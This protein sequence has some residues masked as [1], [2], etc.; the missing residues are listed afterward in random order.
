MT[1]WREYLLPVASI[2]A[3]TGAAWYAR[4][5]RLQAQQKQEE[6]AA[7]V[8][9]AQRANRSP[10]A[11]P[12]PGAVSA[13][14]RWDGSSETALGPE[15]RHPSAAPGYASATA[16]HPSPEEQLAYLGE[17]FERESVDNE[18]AR[19]A[20]ISI[21]DRLEGALPE[22]SSVRSVECR[23]IICK[24]VVS[25]PDRDKYKAYEDRAIRSEASVWTGPL[26]NQVEQANGGQVVSTT[27]LVRDG[28]PV[29]SPFE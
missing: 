7:L 25:H 1:A 4:E 19:D 6:M 23:S 17:E 16:P 26:Y 18:W 13:S 2:A 15:E 10:V 21:N 5:T 20:R 28:A 3:A 11:G 9:S 12:M 29:P 27:Y 24:L 8:A 22:G 14:A